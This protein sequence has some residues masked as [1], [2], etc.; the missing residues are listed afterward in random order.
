MEYKTQFGS[1]ESY[2]KGGVQVINDDA[3]HYAFSNCFEIASISKPYE[4]VVFGIN[5]IYVLEVLRAEGVSPWYTCAHDEFALCMDKEVDIQLVKL[6]AAHQI[7]D[8]E[9][10]GAVLV[11]G[12]PVGARM[13]WMR[14]KRGHQALLPAN[15]AYQFRAAQPGVIVLQTCKG[16]LSV[17]K[18][19]D[20]CQ[21]A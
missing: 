21:A 17:E 4:K 16:D 20:I 2:E 9:K 10:N 15:T 11:Q 3:K 5:Q 19:A 13:G 14:L 18:W 6:D 1:L 8:A 12:E 7:E